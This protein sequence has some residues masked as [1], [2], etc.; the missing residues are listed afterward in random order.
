MV[1]RG[2]IQFR[3]RLPWYTVRS[4][5][6]HRD[7]LPSITTFRKSLWPLSQIPSPCSYIG[8]LKNLT[9]GED[10]VK[11]WGTWDQGVGA[12]TRTKSSS[13]RQIP[14]S[15]PPIQ[16]WMTLCHSGKTTLKERSFFSCPTSHFQRNLMHSREILWL[17]RLTQLS[18]YRPPLNSPFLHHS[19]HLTHDIQLVAHI[20]SEIRPTTF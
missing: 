10:L 7:I 12:W 1:T 15:R 8:K 6:L 20:C 13:A 5:T 14:S 3:C 19:L 11:H 4:R 18:R 9:G 2:V 17:P 16:E